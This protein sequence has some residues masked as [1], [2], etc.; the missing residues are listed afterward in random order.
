M[1]KRSGGLMRYVGKIMNVIDTVRRMLVNLVFLGILV[2]VLLTLRGDIGVSIPDGAAL[3]VSPIGELVEQYEG[4]PSEYALRSFVGAAPRETRVRDLVWAIEQAKDDDRIRALVLQFGEFHGGHLSKLTVVADAIEKFK[5]SGKPVLSYGDAYYQDAYYLAAHADEVHLHPMG[6]VLLEGYG[7]FGKYFKDLL[8]NI[9]V[10]VNVFRVGEFKS[11]VEPF[12]RNDMSTEAREANEDW[13]GDLWTAYKTDVATMR[14]LAAQALQDYS[15][16]FDALIANH[17]G[18]TASLAQNYGLV[19]R[20]SDRPAF[21]ERMID[22]VGENGAGGYAHVFSEDYLFARRREVSAPA[23]PAEI[24]VVVV[25]GAI[26]DGEPMPGSVSGDRIAE[27]IRE[28]RR[29]ETIRAIVLRVDSPG[30]SAFASEVIRRELAL[31]REAGKPVVVSMG[32]VAASGGYWIAT[33]S[34]Q[35]WAS[36]VTITGSIGVFGVIP[37]YEGTLAKLGIY[38]DGVGTTRLAGGLRLDRDLEP[39]LARSIQQMVEGTYRE[40]LKH[41]SDARQMTPEAIDKIARGRVWSGQDAAE[42]G[43]VD[44]MGELPDALDAAAELAGLGDDYTHRYIAPDRQVYEVLF[45]QMRSGV[46]IDEIRR[47]AKH[48]LLDATQV[49]TLIPTVWQLADP[50]GIYAYCDCDPG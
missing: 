9:D 29:D 31:T 11:A 45:D 6:M 33:A 24:G 26:V 20:I 15:D 10:K 50:K 37:T 19:T 25:A 43:L 5:V 30:G 42:L 38:S 17:Q 2:F 36:P 21:R 47:L 23:Q 8:D 49:T 35:I 18:D 28:A 41:I 22:L 44:A 39:Q 16:G 34:D 12:L 1:A 7:V 4:D 46:L 48:I 32:S 27:Q 3:I 13:L 40:F 14:S